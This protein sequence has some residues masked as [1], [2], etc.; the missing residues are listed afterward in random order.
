MTPERW[1]QLDN[2]LNAALEK[3]P[4]ER[5]AFL[6]QV[7]ADDAELLNE[8]ESLLRH[9]QNDDSFLENPPTELAAKFASDLATKHSTEL[10][11]GQKL[12]HY[13]LDR[14]LG[15]GGMGAVYLAHDTRLERQVA[16]KLLPHSSAN[17][18][19]RVQRFR[20]EARAISALNHPNILTIY[21]IGEAMTEFGKT[22]FIATEF[23]EGRTLRV[24]LNAGTLTLGE[25]LDIAIQ[26]ANALAA[27]HKAGVIHRDIK[28]ENLMLRPDG[29]V[30]VL[31]FGLAKLAERN[32]D[33]NS[34]VA[35]SPSVKTKSGIVLG[36]ASYMSPE[37]ARGLD[38]DARSDLFSLGAVLYELISGCQPFFGATTGDVLAALLTTEPSALTRFIPKIPAELQRIVSRALAK[39]LD[40]RYQSATALHDDLKQLKD[41]LTLKA[42]LKR[43][44][45]GN[46][47]IMLELPLGAANPKTPTNSAQTNRTTTDNQPRR[48][49]SLR[50]WLSS[51]FKSGPKPVW[52][53]AVVLLIAIAALG[54]KRF[55]QQSANEVAPITTLAVLPFANSQND[56]KMDYLTDGLTEG[57][58]DNLSQVTPLRVLARATV[59]SYK[60]RNKGHEFDPREAG[61]LLNVGAVVLG[62]LQQQG[63][64]LLV[65]VELVD[66]A[67]GALLWSEQYPRPM[68]D[69]PKVQGEITR[70][71]SSALKLRFSS[72]Q[73]QQL[74]NRH[75]NN[76]EAYQHYLLGRHYLLEATRVSLEK[77]LASYQQA[78][79][80]DPNYALAYAGIA[81]YYGA[82]SAQY[83]PPSEAIPKAIEAAQTAIRLDG[84]LPEAH[85]V[86]A[87]IHFYNWN[88]TGC[89]YEAKR[90]IELNSNFAPAHQI[91][92]SYLLH[93]KRYDEALREA[94]LAKELDPLSP[95]SETAL[96]GIFLFMR[97]YDQALSHYRKALELSQ[98]NSVRRA[99]LGRVLTL[100][101]KY[102]EAIA[103]FLLTFEAEPQPSY[104]AWLA[105][106]YAR[107]GQRN[108]ALKLLRELE[109][110]AQ[111][112]RVSPIYFARVYT[113]LGEKEK[114]LYWLQKTFD[115]HSDH[116]LL[117]GQDPVYDPLRAEPQFQTM[118]RGI[119]AAP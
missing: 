49:A 113:G 40:A 32:A 102:D 44:A 101:G 96:G 97:Q 108:E 86:M 25:A 34:H 36:T 5:A 20:Q 61:K 115:E 17:N 91:Y 39:E 12:N 43:K 103:E 82:V 48:T 72:A 54:V 98:N 30:K 9:Y 42:Q 70:E 112:E 57:V 109:S 94:L 100:Q 23:V 62:R 93:K 56:P 85:F 19:E 68:S 10:T 21:E 4:P 73:Q 18:L 71:V 51:K 15:R 2:L 24:C 107:A 50:T 66:S 92:S 119:G 38:V 95:Q 76:S 59:Y 7:C 45:D 110:L 84:A 99:M 79:A 78:I 22:H 8:V 11:I 89:E 63:N 104:R 60:D 116:I 37:Q 47:P 55:G 83:M 31:D 118:V 65:R 111:R 3:A 87:R 35:E 14:L 6:K 53:V 69:L 41:E 27:A 26:T 52:L 81:E 90:A 106:G 105:Y 33:T 74:S 117:I 46:E 28:P 58:I 77:A 13:Q 29:F 1:Q 67:S 64:L 88:W 75:T 80:L 114:A 16:I